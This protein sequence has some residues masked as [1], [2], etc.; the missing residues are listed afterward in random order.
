[1]H[2]DLYQTLAGLIVGFVIG[3]TGMGGGA[4]MTPVLVL[5][6]GVNPGTAV[7]ADVVTSLVLKPF[8]GSIHV[9]R[10]TVNWR[11]VQW[12]MIGSVPSAFLGAYLLDDV[13]GTS[14]KG[15]VKA[16]LGWV[17]LVAAGAILAKLL[18]QARRRE[19]PVTEMMS[20]SLVQPLPTLV[21]GALGGLVVGMTSVGS[22]SLIIVMLMML[23]PKLSSREM[24]G[25]DPIQ[26]IPLV[27]AAAVGHD[28]FGTLDISI[29]TSVLLGAIPAV[30]VGAHFSSRGTDRYIRP[31]LVAVLVISSLGLLGVTNGWLLVAAVVEIGALGCRA[32]AH[33][34]ERG[35]RSRRHHR[36][37]GGSL[38]GCVSGWL[39]CNVGKV[40][41][42]RI[43]ARTRVLREARGR[44]CSLAVF[45]EMSLTG[46]VDPERHP[47]HL[48][49]LDH[50]AVVAMAGVTAET[51]V[52][53][54]FGI[55]ERSDR[56]G[57]ATS[58]R[59]RRKHGRVI[60]VQ[61]KRH[62]G[63]GEE[64]YTRCRH[65]H[66]LRPGRRPLRDRVSVRNPVWIDRL[67][68]RRRSTRSSR[69]CAAPGLW[70]RRLDEASRRRGL[71]WWCAEGLGD[72]RRH[73]GERGLWIA[74]GTQAGSTEDEDSRA[75]PP[76]ST[77]PAR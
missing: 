71:E 50:P 12:L 61:R 69:S 35:A 64:A 75:S 58:R 59:S 27:G 34:S 4:L 1:M 23:Y 41:S 60:G 72:A 33:A 20:P 57:R 22:G 47:D 55:S 53:A 42:T 30:M 14:N 37:C 36:R 3:L 46:S 15:H 65:R 11:L 31:V 40:R 56:G 18:L 9:R 7:S 10:G 52:G 67:R 26:A 16:V 62:L 77:R 38:N 70:G 25:T 48:I 45:P 17:L 39:R 74:I 13:I 63:Q 49:A 29:I 24:V 43:S 73:A 66:R 76:W 2:L 5:L 28:L 51:G 44:G 32:R 8:G 21:I 6:F 54:V 68:T 19:K